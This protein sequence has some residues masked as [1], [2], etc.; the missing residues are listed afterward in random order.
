MVDLTPY[1][2]GIEAAMNSAPAV[3]TDPR[4]SFLNVLTAEGFAAPKVLAIGRL[5]RID[6][7]EDRRGKKSAWYVYNEIEDNQ[8]SGQIIGVASYGDWKTGVSES[9]CSRSEH[10]MNTAE[11]NSYRI[12][13]EA[14]RLEY[15]RE[16]AI[17]QKEAAAR[18]FEIWSN[19]PQ[20]NDD[21]PYLLA[22]GV[23]A[24]DGVKLSRDGDLI[25]PSAVDNEIVSLQYIRD[26][27]F[28]INGEPIGNKK[29]LTGGRTKGGWFVIEGETDVIYIAEGYA[30]S[31]SVHEATG[32][33]T[34]I[35]YNAGNLYEVASYVKNTWPQSRIIISGDDDTGTAG[36]AGRT[37]AE[38]AA[39][40]LGIECVF[41]TGVIDFNDMHKE[42]GIKALREY[43]NPEKLEA[44]EAVKK[45]LSQA[46]ERQ[47]GILGD[48]ADY[49]HATSG[50][51]QH[52]FAIQTALAIT[53]IILGRGYK[54]SLEN[55]TSLYLLNVAKSGTGKEHA[56]TIIEKILYEC[57]S[58][59]L[60][61]GDGYTSAGAVFSTLLDRPRHISVIDE[62]GRYLEAGRD[63]KG[64]NHHQR[65]A[66]T[67]LMESIGRAHS[68]IRPP[69]YSSMTLK[70]DAADAI[71]NRQVHNPAITLLTMTTPDT[72]FSTLD[73]G[74]IK[75]GFINR[76]IISIS[77][78]EREIRKHKQPIDVPDRII[79]WVHDVTARSDKAHIANEPAAPVV[80]EFSSEAMKKQV[81]FQK[82]CIDQANYL[83]R[84][85]MAELTGRSNEMAMRLSLICALA[86]DA[87]ANEISGDDMD[88]GIGYVRHCLEKT[89]DRLKISVSHS[90][91]EHQKKEI[92]ADL[93]ERSTEGITW[94]QMQKTAPYSQH[95]PKDLKEI[96]QSLKDADLAG[97]EAYQPDGGGRPTTKWKALK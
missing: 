39:Q 8:Q 18:A 31:A 20:A 81:E 3:C 42:L 57:G 2:S 33:T 29:F 40:G 19:S 37:K 90:S 41:P 7:N 30:T 32:K 22:K 54:T 58:G 75:D 97:D 84:F 15:E 1:K 4:A 11:R 45:P 83:E 13:R 49:Y 94:S 79:R 60:I 87:G 65:E 73:M 44:Y 28:L 85:G 96:M 10:Q 36:N 47:P 51:D 38:Q 63:L 9:W 86:R 93:R 53:S 74:A 55:Y 14:M 16:T 23:K 50:N 25:I 21:H 12:A 68:L 52:G 35:A 92:L 82:Y 66:N 78:A 27:D 69:S 70:K 89:I 95:K 46:V 80:L 24:Y 72:L 71:K 59:H 5:D 91:F 17:K 62:F 26:G 56:K 48:I 67:K 88:W 77:D 34:Y 6:G 61:A 43:L 76:F 64:G